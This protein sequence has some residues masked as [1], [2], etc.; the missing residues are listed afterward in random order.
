[1]T[2]ADAR[3]QSIFSNNFTHYLYLNFISPQLEGESCVGPWNLYGSCGEELRC[4]DEGMCVRSKE[5]KQVKCEVN[6]K[7]TSQVASD[8]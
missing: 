4:T 2:S 6:E 1:M 8:W 5:V 3:T 7:K